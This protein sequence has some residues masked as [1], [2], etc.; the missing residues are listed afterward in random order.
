MKD[1]LVFRYVS[2]MAKCLYEYVIEQF[3]SN[4]PILHESYKLKNLIAYFVQPVKVQWKETK[5]GWSFDL[6]ATGK[7][8]T[9]CAYGRF[10]NK[11]ILT[12]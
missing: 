6:L 5:Q 3:S 1:N 10:G 4:T 7:N 12:V 8:S 9:S 11:P 2:A